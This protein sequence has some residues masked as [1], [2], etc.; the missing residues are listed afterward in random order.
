MIVWFC[1]LGLNFICCLHLQGYCRIKYAL[2]LLQ[3]HSK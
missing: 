2:R 3:C 1:S